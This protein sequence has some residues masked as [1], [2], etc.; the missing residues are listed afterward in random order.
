MVSMPRWLPASILSGHIW[1][2]L[3]AAFPAFDI[4]AMCFDLLIAAVM[5]ASTNWLTDRW[6]SRHVLRFQPQWPQWSKRLRGPS[7]FRY[8]LRTLLLLPVILAV[9]LALVGVNPRSASGLGERIIDLLGVSLGIAVL[10]IVLW[11]MKQAR[12]L[13]AGLQALL[14]FS[15]LTGSLGGALWLSSTVLSVPQQ[16]SVWLPALQ[17]VFIW[18]LSI[19]AVVGATYAIGWIRRQA[20][21]SQWYLRAVVALSVIGG[22]MTAAV[23]SDTSLLRFP[24][25]NLVWLLSVFLGWGILCTLS[26]VAS[27][28]ADMAR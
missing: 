16:P 8:S 17:G 1:A 10:C 3:A 11:S 18:L 12:P 13:R 25:G 24:F 2:A 15:L 14:W 9:V 20:R 26:F 5:L 21:P 19:S 7:R 4:G 27:C 6:M 22:V 23:F 28:V